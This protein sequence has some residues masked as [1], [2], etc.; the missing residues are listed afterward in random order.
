MT[1]AL[2]SNCWSS[3]SMAM[4]L[5][6][7]TTAVTS[8]IGGRGRPAGCSSAN[9]HGRLFGSIVTVYSI[10]RLGSAASRPPRILVSALHSNPS[11]RDKT[12]P[13]Q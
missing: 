12:G 7:P 11:K 9:S 8:S 3:V 10:A 6:G 4:L 2:E 1:G 13:R 5:N